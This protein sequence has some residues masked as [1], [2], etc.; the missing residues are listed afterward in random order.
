MRP[1]SSSLSIPAAALFRARGV[2]D[3][4]EGPAGKGQ[5]DAATE[6]WHERFEATGD[7]LVLCTRSQRLSE[8]ERE[9][10]TAVLLG[11]LMLVDSAADTAAE[12]LKLLGATGAGTLPVL[13]ALSGEGRL[14][15]E[16]IISYDDI[17]VELSERRI[18]L[19]PVL[20]DFVLH[21]HG[22]AAKG[23][24]VEHE[25]H[26]REKLLA[27]T[28]A[29]QRKAR[30]FEHFDSPF[31]RGRG[32][33]FKEGRRVQ[34]LLRLLQDTLDSLQQVLAWKPGGTAP[35][36]RLIGPRAGKPACRRV[37]LPTVS[38]FLS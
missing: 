31:P 21:E 20:V 10:A 8:T 38:A 2:G 32:D 35:P 4:E 15:T 26:L 25:E 29:L 28:R 3:D 13:R 19:D 1:R 37:P 33:I 17:D 7:E 30:A 18:V 12:I 24:D 16:R 5:A 34:R 11:R 14:Y 23:W 9:V 27:L 22:A 36:D 6:R